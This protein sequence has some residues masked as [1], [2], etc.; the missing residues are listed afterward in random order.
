MLEEI[1]GE[2]SDEH[3]RASQDVFSLKQGG[4]LVNASIPLE[5]LTEL[6]GIT[7]ETEESL[8]WW[9]FTNSFSIYPKKV[10]DCYIKNFIF[11]FKRQA[12]AEY[13]KY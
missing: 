1:V 5:E 11:K 4:W 13:Y 12:R 9:F 10:N 6:L 7:F 3:E 8:N 2:I